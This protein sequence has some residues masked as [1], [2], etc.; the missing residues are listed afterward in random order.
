MLLK[1]QFLRGE[2]DELL[3]HQYRRLQL[4]GEMAMSKSAV[5]GPSIFTKEYLRNGVPSAWRTARRA[6]AL[7]LID[8]M[9]GSNVGRPLFCDV[10]VG[11]AP[12]GLPIIFMTPSARDQH[13]ECLREAAI[14]CPIHWELDCQASVKAHEL[15]KRILTIPC[16]HRYDLEDM[17]RVVAI[18]LK[19]AQVGNVLIEARQ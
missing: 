10:P 4:S 5:T 13:R 14:Y 2:G 7:R 8:G 6:N 3:K 15:Q 11:S 18:L 17:N 16:D 12:F 1:E 19:T 9:A